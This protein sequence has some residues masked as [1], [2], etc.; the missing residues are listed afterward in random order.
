MHLL[1]LRPGLLTISSR[2]FKRPHRF[3]RFSLPKHFHPISER[4][5]QDSNLQPPDLESGALSNSS[6]CPPGSHLRFFMRGMG[7]TYRAKFPPYEFVGRKFLVFRSRVIPVFTLLTRESYQVP[8]KDSSLFPYSRIF[9]T[10][11]AP[12]V[13]PPSRIAKRKP[14]SIAMGVSNAT[15]I[16]VLSPGITISVPSCSSTDPVTSVVRK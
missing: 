13:R 14:S 2:R 11:P 16:W 3:P 9:V 7:T 6:Y 12:P 15:V 1:C 8:H 5:R 4:V 10:T